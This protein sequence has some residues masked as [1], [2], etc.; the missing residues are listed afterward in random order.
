MV[1]AFNLI[2]Q[3]AER[4][5]N[6]GPQ[7]FSFFTA[8]DPSHGMLSLHSGSGFSLQLNVSGVALWIHA[9]VCFHVG[10]TIGQVNQDEP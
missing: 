3:E 2:T 7:L 6:A 9:E 5:M 1:H 4:Q 10:S 8:K